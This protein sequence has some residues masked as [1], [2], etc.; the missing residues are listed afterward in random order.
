MCYG[1]NDVI[2]LKFCQ[3]IGVAWLL[4]FQQLQWRHTSLAFGVMHAYM[5]F[6]RYHAGHDVEYAMQYRVVGW[7]KQGWNLAWNE[8]LIFLG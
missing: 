4:M 1:S 2:G 8:C 3:E 7:L 5:E 6:S